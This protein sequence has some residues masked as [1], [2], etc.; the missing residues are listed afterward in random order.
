MQ[1]GA[2][3]AT[4]EEE[5]GEEEDDDKR[6]AASPNV[7]TLL[8]YFPSLALIASPSIIMHK[9]SRDTRISVLSKMSHLLERRSSVFI[10]VPFSETDPRR[11]TKLR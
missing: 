9:Y 8:H 2:S 5:K 3:G 1:P 4:E 10:Y 6:N 11:F 7:G